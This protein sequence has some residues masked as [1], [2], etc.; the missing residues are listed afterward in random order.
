[1][2]APAKGVTGKVRGFKSHP[3][4]WPWRSPLVG[5]A[6]V[7]LSAVIAALVNRKVMAPKFLDVVFLREMCRLFAVR[8]RSGLVAGD[9]KWESRPSGEFITFRVKDRRG[10]GTQI[11]G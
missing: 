2:R 11:N 4:R 5:R 7:K 10:Y 9:G 3:L 8:N 1:M 6:R